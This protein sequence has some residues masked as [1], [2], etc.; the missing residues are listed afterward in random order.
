[1]SS[2]LPA[3]GITDGA[4]VNVADATTP[5]TLEFVVVL[6]SMMDTREAT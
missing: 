5:R 4:T 2:F 3:L 6:T 1:M